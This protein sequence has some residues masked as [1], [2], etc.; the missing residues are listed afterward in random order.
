MQNR[1]NAGKNKKTV[2]IIAIALLLVLALALGGFTFAKYISQ[3]SG[4]DTARVA[5][6]GV[7]ITA[8]ADS[9][10][11]ASGY[12]KGEGAFAEKKE[13]G[14]AVQANTSVVAPGTR[15]DGAMAVTISGTPEVAVGISYFM[16]EEITDVELVLT[17][18]EGPGPSV[19][20]YNPI[21]YTLMKDGEAQLKGTLEQIKDAV[22]GL[23]EQT[24]AAGTNLATAN[25]AKYSISWE[26]AFEN[27][28]VQGIDADVLDTILGNDTAPNSEVNINGTKYT[29]T[30]VSTAINYTMGVTVEQIQSL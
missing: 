21:K 6:W 8:V 15:G 22:N 28:D 9:S 2:L 11:F 30:T 17:R 18:K 1:E 19:I 27:E 24:F 13:S 10:A 26:W 3:G 14:V 29:L 4:S 12:S 5:K 20:V 25:F 7:S 23:A 16:A